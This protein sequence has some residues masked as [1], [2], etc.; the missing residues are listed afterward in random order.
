MHERSKRHAHI[1]YPSAHEFYRRSNTHDPNEDGFEDLYCRD[2]IH[3]ISQVA[4][5]KLAHHCL[6]S[7]QRAAFRHGIVCHNMGKEEADPTLELAME[8]ASA[9]GTIIFDESY[10]LCNLTK[11]QVG[12]NQFAM[13]VAVD[14]L[15][16]EVDHTSERLSALEGKVTDLEAG[17]T[18]LLALGQEQ[19]E[20]STHSVH[21]LGQLVTMV[22]AQQGKIRTMEEQMNAMREMILVLEHIQE[23]PIVVDEEETAVSDRSGEELEVEE[24]EVAISIPVPGRLVPIEDEIQ[25][26]PNELVGMQITFELVEKDCP[27][28]YK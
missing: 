18:E 7:Y 6:D 21:A 9:L 28:S 20:T 14:Q 23:N 19:L 4:C 25:I 10:C 11:A 2:F 16:G 13:D 3:T 15:D 1:K 12:R 5:H 27:P 22:L 8:Y 26:L 24:N 17:Y